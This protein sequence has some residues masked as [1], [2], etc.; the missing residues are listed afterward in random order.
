MQC[1]KR[2]R[3]GH[4]EGDPHHHARLVLRRAKEHN[5]D[6]TSVEICAILHG[7]M[8][9]MDKTKALQQIMNLFWGRLKHVD[10]RDVLAA[11]DRAIREVEN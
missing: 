7:I 4:Q 1:Q 2:W 8:S 3:T 11:A 10:H 5:I 9:G 6:V